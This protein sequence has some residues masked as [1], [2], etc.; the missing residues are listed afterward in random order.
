[1]VAVGQLK[2]QSLWWPGECSNAALVG[3]EPAASRITSFP[4][5]SVKHSPAATSETSREQGQG[6][7]SK[8][9]VD[10]SLQIIICTSPSAGATILIWQIRT[11]KVKV[12][13]AGKPDF[14]SSPP[15][16]SVLLQ[17][18][19]DDSLWWQMPDI[20]PPSVAAVLR[21]GL[22]VSAGAVSSA[23]CTR[24]RSDAPSASDVRRAGDARASTFDKVCVSARVNM[25]ASIHAR[26]MMI[27]TVSS[28]YYMCPRTPMSV[29]SAKTNCLVRIYVARNR[30]TD[31]L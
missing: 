19:R 11:A 7:L 14:R 17:D 13:S 12:D 4:K 28:T 25:R 1:M 18:Q 20:A 29:S 31:P 6:N 16:P 24:R 30:S 9:F 10:C 2:R 27:L 21:R 26:C 3:E 5:L 22:D 23:V 8:T 15:A